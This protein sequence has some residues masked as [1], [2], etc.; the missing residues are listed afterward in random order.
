MARGVRGVSLRLPSP[1]VLIKRQF[2]EE[3]E[4]DR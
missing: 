4:S 2:S 1:R 3:V